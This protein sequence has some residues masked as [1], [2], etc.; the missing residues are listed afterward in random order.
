MMMR[1]P[2]SPF[3]PCPSQLLGSVLLGCA[4]IVPVAQ[5]QEPA[6]QEQNQPLDFSGAVVIGAEHNNN[7]SVAELESASGR[8]DTAAT[9]DANIDM[10]WQPD[11]R[12]AAA[13]GYSYSASRY[14]D[15][16]SYD[17]DMHLLYADV[18]Y[19][20]D[21]VTLGGNYYYADA[22]L[23]SDRFLELNQY[24][25]YAGKLFGEKWYLRGAM[26]FT[27]KEFYVFDARNADNDGFGVDVY[28]FFNAG[29]S[30]VTL[31]YA[32][33]D[34][35]TRGPSFSYTADT[36]RLRLNHRF[37]LAERESRL[38]LGYRWQDRDYANIT[39]SINAPRDDSQQV[40][41]VRLEVPMM[42]HVAVVGR[43]EH[44]NYQSRLASADFTDNRISL[45]VQLS[46]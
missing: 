27:E 24:S 21:L 28:H 37:M 3:R 33:E 16:D 6:Q 46:F 19:D 22:D 17:L 25:L 29:R 23:G 36:L 43:W 2:Y 8:S 20:F 7:L 44:G 10:S 13:A 15:L 11:D 12:F 26:N 1:T 38:Q 35:D 30:N 45:A 34:E 42:E 41:D 31:G 14:Q 5:A 40:A 39:Q 4:L 9:L 18:S 32:Y